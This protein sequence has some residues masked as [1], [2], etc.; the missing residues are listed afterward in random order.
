MKPSRFFGL[1]AQP[2]A[3]FSLFLAALPF[4][5]L[6]VV[7]AVASDARIAENPDDKLLP[8]F[9]SMYD[10]IIRMATEPDRRSGALLLWSDTFASMTRLLVGVVLGSVIGL[11]IGLNTSIYPGLRALSRS[12]LTFLSIIPPLTILPILFIIFGVGET[13]KIALIFIGTVFVISR[14]LQLY[15]MQMPR[16]QIIKALTLGASELAV[17]YRVVLPQ[18]MPRL[19]D[20]TRLTL[21]AAW[22]FLIAAEMISAT[23]GLGYRIGLVRRYLAM[24][25]IIPYVL[26]I[27][28]LGFMLD[29][30]LRFAVEKLYPWYGLEK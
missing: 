23:E 10:A 12:F 1:H 15:V 16:E 2:S 26:W 18:I 13:A 8:S 22:L 25:V 28:L 7:Y 9:T 6:L 5:L 30:L 27:T 11:L 20:T 24:D 3:G 4:V 29:W 17:S 21:G 14:D 19:L